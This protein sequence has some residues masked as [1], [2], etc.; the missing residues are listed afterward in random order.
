MHFDFTPSGENERLIGEAGFE[1]EVSRDVT[2]NMAE[3]SKRMCDSRARYRDE[4]LRIE[5]EE[6]FDATQRFL[7]NMHL[8]SSERRLS[9]YAFVARKPAQ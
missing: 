5:S 9:R 3:I 7:M 1:L 6:E 4:V 2:E 8:L